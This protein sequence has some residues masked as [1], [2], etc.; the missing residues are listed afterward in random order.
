MTIIDMIASIVCLGTDP[1]I[2]IGKSN[3]PREQ[4][5]RRYLSLTSE[6]LQYVIECV[7]KQK[8]HIKNIRSYYLVS[9]WNAPDTIELYYHRRVAEDLGYMEYN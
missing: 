9:L 6:H 3:Y 8:H 2:K 1:V 4:V 5:K 7:E